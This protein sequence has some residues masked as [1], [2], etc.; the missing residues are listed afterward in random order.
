VRSSGILKCVFHYAGRTFARPCSPD[1]AAGFDDGNDPHAIALAID[2]P[3]SVPLLA[4]RR[5]IRF[6]CDREYGVG[7]VVVVPLR[8]EL[9]F[10]RPACA[11]PVTAPCLVTVKDVRA[12]VASQPDVAIPGVV[13]RGG[14]AG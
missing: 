7:D 4:L 8:G 14:R 1:I 3:A 13:S 9:C 12:P 6:A 5:L 11:V 2:L 10:T